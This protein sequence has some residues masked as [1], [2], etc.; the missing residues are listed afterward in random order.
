VLVMMHPCCLESKSVVSPGKCP[1]PRTIVVIVV[2]IILSSEKNILCIADGVYVVKSTREGVG[3]RRHGHNGREQLR[4]PHVGN[5][6][7]LR[8]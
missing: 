8:R 3:D 6:Y 5:E 2:V 4:R 7:L 1:A